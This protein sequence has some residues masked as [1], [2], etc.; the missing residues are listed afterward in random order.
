MFGMPRIEAQ[1]PAREQRQHLFHFRGRPAR[2]S[3]LCSVHRSE[4]QSAHD[5]TKHRQFL[6]VD[7]RQGFEAKPA[8]VKIRAMRGFELQAFGRNITERLQ[9]IFLKNVDLRSGEQHM[10]LHDQVV[11]PC[12]RCF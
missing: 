4:Q 11:A 2:M 3:R 8:Q 5:A 1:Y 12:T 10:N 6:F 7:F 9:A